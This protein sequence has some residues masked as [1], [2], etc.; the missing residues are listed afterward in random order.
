MKIYCIKAQYRQYFTDSILD[1]IITWF[2]FLM[3]YRTIPKIKK[4][5]L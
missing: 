3:D 1:A 2:D 5:P 4:V